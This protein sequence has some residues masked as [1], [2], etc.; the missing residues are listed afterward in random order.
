MKISTDPRL[1]PDL[2]VLCIDPRWCLNKQDA[3]DVANDMHTFMEALRLETSAL[4]GDF[5]ATT[6]ESRKRKGYDQRL[7]PKV[8][9]PQRRSVAKNMDLRSGNPHVTGGSRKKKLRSLRRNS[10]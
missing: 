6:D 7:D 10:Q 1:H 9:I 4:N 3:D 8:T 5:N 2:F